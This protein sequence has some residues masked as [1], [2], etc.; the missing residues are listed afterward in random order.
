MAAREIEK[1]VA[2]AREFAALSDYDAALMF[3]HGLDRE[4]ETQAG[5]STGLMKSRWEA[6][7]DELA[8]EAQLVKDLQSELKLYISPA[9]AARVDQPRAV[10]RVNSTG[11]NDDTNIQVYDSRPVRRAEPPP[12]GIVNHGLYGDP[13][14]FGPDLGAHPAPERGRWGGGGGGDYGRNPA[15]QPVRRTNSS[16]P[17]SGVQ[18]QAPSSVPQAPLQRVDSKPKVK[19]PLPQAAKGGA[20]KVTGAK[21]PVKGGVDVNGKT[22]FVP[23]AGDEDLVAS[24]QAA[25]GGA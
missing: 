23:R 19:P 22:P 6:L 11:H 14:K 1:S 18:H 5:I 16:G 20:G 15:P 10:R 9:D 7:R 25:K 2:R 24:I 8:V 4:L 13:D 12:V 21:G 17:S 3:Y